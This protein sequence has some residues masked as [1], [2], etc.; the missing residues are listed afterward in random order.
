[1]FKISDLIT[2]ILFVAILSLFGCSGPTSIK[3]PDVL[4]DTFK[5]NIRKVLDDYENRPVYKVLTSEIIDRSSDND[6]LQIVIDNLSEKFPS[7]NTKEYK[8]FLSWNKPQQAI[9]IISILEDEINN[10][11][12]SQYYFNSSG[13]YANLAPEAFKMVGALAFENLTIR[14]N[15]IYNM[16]YSKITKYQDDSGEG[17]G[18]SKSHEENPLNKFDDEFYKLEKTE[19][20]EKLLVKFIRKNKIQFVDK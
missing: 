3:K 2:K 17:I 15:K 16:E 11:G 10:G 6:L 1:M 13:Q 14:A 12:F 19:N 5:K 9:Y 7:D 4:S 20:L 18:I 8:T